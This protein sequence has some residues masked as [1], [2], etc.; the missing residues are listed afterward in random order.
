MP[1]LRVKSLAKGFQVFDFTE[2]PGS[3]Q[4]QLELNLDLVTTEGMR[5]KTDKEKKRR[6][7]TSPSWPLPEGYQDKSHTTVPVLGHTTLARQFTE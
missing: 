6:D 7:Q 1:G 2:G 5:S 4:V 3:A